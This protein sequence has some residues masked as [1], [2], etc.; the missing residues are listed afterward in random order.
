ME[1]G[2]HLIGPAD[3]NEHLRV[4]IRV[5]Q[6]PDAPLLPD[7]A[8]WAKTPPKK[9]MFLTREELA[10]RHGA[11]QKDVERVIEFARVAGLEIIEA[12]AGKR[13]VTVAGTVEQMSRAFAVALGRYQS[14]EAP[15]RGREGWIHLPEA[16]AALVEGVLGLDNRPVGANHTNP[17]D[18]LGF[19]QLLVQQIAAAYNFP[20][21][22]ATNQV[23]GIPTFDGGGYNLSDLQAFFSA[24]TLPFTLT[25]VP[26]GANNPG[27]VATDFELTQDICV[28]GTVAQGANI[29]IYYESPSTTTASSGW[30]DFLTRA[31]MPTGSEPKPTVLSIS[32]H[33]SVGD[34]Q[35]SIIA[36]GFTAGTILQL[37]TL[38]QQAAA[39]GITVFMSSGDKGSNFNGSK[40][41]VTW[42]SS[43][44]WVTACG[45]TTLTLNN[46]GSINEEWVWNDTYQGADFASGGGISDNPN[47]VLPPYQ[48]GVVEQASL[49]DNQ[50]RRGVPDIAGNA[51]SNTGQSI[52]VDTTADV[53]NG[54]S[55]VSPLYAGLMAVINAQLGQSIGILNPTLYALRAMVCRDINDNQYPG[56]PTDNGIGASPGYPSGPGWDA[57]TGLGVVDGGALLAALQQEFQPNCQLVVD[58]AQIGKDEVSAALTQAT[59]AII[60]NVFYVIVDGFTPATLHVTTNDLTGAP[61]HVPAFTVD[62]NLFQLVATALLAVDVAPDGSLLVNS[63]QRLTWV[64]AASFADTSAF[65]SAPQSVAVSATIGG[66]TGT[67]TIRLV[68]DADPYEL[69]GAVSWLSEDVRVFQVKTNG[70]LPGVPTVQLQ[71][72]G[73]PRVDAP[74][75]I[76]SLIDALRADTTPPPNH[77]FDQISTDEDTSEV[78]IASQDGNGVQVQNFAV[79]R[80]R[81]QGTQPS[82]KV[83]VFFRLFQAATTSTAYDLDTYAAFASGGANGFRIPLFGVEGNDVVAIPCFASARTLPLATLDTQS[84]DKNVLASLEPGA[85][86]APVYSY[87]GCWLDINESTSK[88]IP[89]PPVLPQSIGP[90]SNY[91]TVLS[92]VKGIHQCVVA[93]IS[94]DDDPIQTGQTPASSDKLA[95]RNLSIVPSANPGDLASHRIPLTFSLRATATALANRPLDELM[96]EWGNTPRGSRA[97]IFMPAIASQ[98]ILTLA[99]ELYSTNELERIDDHTLSVRVAGATYIPLPAGVGASAAGLLTLDLPPAVRKGQVF[100]VVARQLTG[101]GQPRSKIGNRHVLGAFQLSIPVS[102]KQELLLPETRNLSVLRWIGERI[103]PGDRWSRVFER[104]LEQVA[105]RVRALGGDPAH[106]ASSPTGNGQ[107]QHGHGARVELTGKISGLLYDQFGD[108]DGFLLETHIGEQRF[109]SREHAVAELARHAFAEHVRLS[110]IVARHEPHRPLSIVLRH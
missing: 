38:L 22:P 57:C 85:H 7:L 90:F 56:S 73:N 23:I 41:R 31:I 15:Y 1:K 50:L 76:S 61:T 11:T 47:Y 109:Y 17:G 70:F 62:Q 105:D 103:R 16:V 67:G 102:T 95:Q 68:A 44:P 72:N 26:S 33:I 54:T 18:P 91:E 8:H 24:N 82:G 45:G 100:T 4:I 39:V 48:I 55:A 58:H 42:P 66:V 69:D 60:N 64:C 13:I 101:G 93:E 10:A 36:N 30:I 104:Y 83:R 20:T 21:T 108:F 98:T 2:A 49:N 52:S 84:D 63:T 74:Q 107:T 87:F 34:D 43:N 106:V 51:S 78:T 99:A 81:Y 3:A 65:N 40:Y 77:P 9:R 59:P 32:R 14:G 92:Y 27:M 35:A 89:L 71:D 12:H 29:A 79:A 110:V 6:R 86:G 46:D 53:V 96:I 28:A 25:Q 5:R 80:V 75:F 94:Y 37:E 88:V 19:A 97:Q